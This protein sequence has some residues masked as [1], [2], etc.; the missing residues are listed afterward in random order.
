MWGFFLNQKKQK[1]A[2]QSNLSYVLS[3]INQEADNQ[4]VEIANLESTINKIY[5]IPPVQVIEPP[6]PNPQDI[7]DQIMIAL[8]RVS[9]NT[10]KI[11]ALN[12]HLSKVL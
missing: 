9:A 10:D 2:N 3:Q 7:S 1:M 11:K 4:E 6:T 5:F 8:S 12:D